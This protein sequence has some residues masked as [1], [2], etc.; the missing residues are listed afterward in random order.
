MRIR[1]QLG[2]GT[3]VGVRLPR[4]GRPTA[5]PGEFPDTLH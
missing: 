1:S 3:I 2:V 5:E 4:E